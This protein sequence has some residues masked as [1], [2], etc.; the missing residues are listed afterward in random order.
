MRIVVITGRSRSDKGMAV[1]RADARL[2][3]SIEPTESSLLEVR[4]TAPQRSKAM[5]MVGLFVSGVAAIALAASVALVGA[6]AAQD[7]AQD[8]PNRPVRFVV[9]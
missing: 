2:G 4:R 9:P 5:R 8:Y 6:A 1:R 7:E 3:C